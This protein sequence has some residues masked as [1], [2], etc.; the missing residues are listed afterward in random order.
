M[1]KEQRMPHPAALNLKPEDFQKIGPD[2]KQSEVIQR[3]SLSS[4]RDSWERLRKN[5][6]AMTGLIIMILIVIM[7][8]IGPMISKYDYETNDLM[9]TNMPPSSEHWFGTDDLGRDVFVRTWMGARISLT[10]GLAAAAIDLMIGVIY[11]GIMG[12]FG[13]RV[14]EFMNKFA[15]ILY[16]IPYLLVTILL[17]V[18]FEPSLGTIILA[19][20]ITGW[21]NMSWIVRGEIM[22]LKSREYVLASRS[23][24][25][26][27]ARLLF[28]HLIPNAMGPIIVTLTLSVPSA[29]FAEAFLS[30]LGL[31]V[32][33][34]VAS[35]GS[36]INDAL[37]GWMYY[38]WRML[39][40]ALFISLTM[41]AF[42]IFGDGLRDA[43][44][45]KLK[46]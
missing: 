17:L 44:D 18:V 6:L 4:W 28:R 37:S 8:I 27:T 21:I 40:P 10:V 9:N 1:E 32:Q 15:E 35:W 20:T 2:E 26:G 31:G 22:Q 11:G 42:N 19:L 23:M 12:Y 46:K 5:K 24:G 30:F 36:M 33:A 41:L 25:A 7:A 43:L 45:P 16:S 34:P 29:I 3:E 39:F 38:P 13:G 14:D